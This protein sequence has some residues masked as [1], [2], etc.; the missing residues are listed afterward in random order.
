MLLKLILRT[1]ST[2]WFK[3]ESQAVVTIYTPSVLPFR[4]GQKVVTACTPLAQVNRTV[5]RLTVSKYF[6]TLHI[7]VYNRTN[8]ISCTPSFWLSLGVLKKKFSALNVP[9]SVFK[10][11]LFYQLQR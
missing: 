6:T 3:Q 10:E 2:T 1:R 11:L 4:K 5:Q 7:F 9:M 8:L